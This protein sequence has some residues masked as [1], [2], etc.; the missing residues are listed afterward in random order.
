VKSEHGDLA[1]GNESPA[2]SAG[3]VTLTAQKPNYSETICR[4]TNFVH[5][6]TCIDRPRT[7]PGRPH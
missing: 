1:G 7:E 3:K 2:W 6:I 4:S 5:H